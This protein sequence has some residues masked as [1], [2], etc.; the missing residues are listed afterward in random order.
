MDIT[1]ILQAVGSVG[2]PIVACCYMFYLN[3]GQTEA[4]EKEVQK[5]VEAL[6][7]W[8]LAINTLINKLS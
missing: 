8:K 7:E 6:N 1:A 3:Q 4:H 2:F 5:Y